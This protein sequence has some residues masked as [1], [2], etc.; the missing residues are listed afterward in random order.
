MDFVSAYILGLKNCADHIRRKAEGVQLFQ[1]FK[2]RQKYTFWPQE[3]KEFTTFMGRIGLQW[4]LVP[5]W[6]DQANR[7]IEAWIM[8]LCEKAEST[9]QASENGEKVEVE[10]YPTVYAQLRNTLLK[11]ASKSA[12]PDVNF[13][14]AKQVEGLRLTIAS[15]LLD[16]TLA[17]F[18]TSGIALTWLAWQ[19]SR[20]RNAHWQR[21]VRED[22]ESLNGSLDAKAID[23]LPNLH[24]VLMESLRLHAPIPGNQ[25]RMTPSAPTTLGDAEAGIA[26]E[27]LPPGVRVQAQAWSLHRN[28]TAFPDPENWC[29]DRWLDKD[30]QA[31][32]EMN[33]WFW[34]FGS[35]GRM[36]VGS[37][38]A[39]LDMKATIVGIWA[40]FSTEVVEDAG[41]VPNTGYMAEPLGIGPGGKKG[42]GKGRSFLKVKLTELTGAD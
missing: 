34:A 42:I 32:R 39:M 10:D 3:L 1:D 24:A 13:N 2:A 4:L 38:L 26:Y 18:D 8:G 16:H 37:N 25:P 14:I 36:C 21:K 27:S 11:E 40:S 31:Q 23:A 28:P 33:R 15:E 7:E 22:I 9:L 17:G 5:T 12:E 41:M 29:P 35:G 30:S 6:V 20:P 19:L